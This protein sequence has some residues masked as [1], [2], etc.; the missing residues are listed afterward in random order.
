M[1]IV[2]IIWKIREISG[3][4]GCRRK[5]QPNGKSRI[6]SRGESTRNISNARRRAAY[7]DRSCFLRSLPRIRDRFRSK[8]RDGLT[9]RFTRS[10]ITRRNTLLKADLSIKNCT[11]VRRSHGYLE[12][13][14]KGSLPFRKIAIRST[15]Q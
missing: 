11:V 2:I 9:S 10:D 14:K 1:A 5:M 7:P 6:G 12:D 13:L 3:G 15:P 8:D 4:P